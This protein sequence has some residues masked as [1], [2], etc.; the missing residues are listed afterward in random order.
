[1]NSKFHANLYAF[2]VRFRFLCVFLGATVIYLCQQHLHY[3]YMSYQKDKIR[4]SWGLSTNTEHQTHT[5][6]LKKKESA[7]LDK[8][9]DLQGVFKDFTVISAL[10]MKI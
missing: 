9:S 3:I 8:I 7:Q 4:F 5:I 10:Y 1:M 6:R 2:Q